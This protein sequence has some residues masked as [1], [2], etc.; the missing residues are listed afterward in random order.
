[1]EVLEVRV[2]EPTMEQGRL[3]VSAVVPTS[4]DRGI[5]L[6][7]SVDERLAPAVTSW[8]GPFV[9]VALW[10]AAQT[11]ATLV[12]TGAPVSPSLLRNL[13]RFQ[14]VWGTWKG[15]PVVPI[16]AEEQRERPGRPPAAVAACSGGVDSAFTV[17]RHA[18][19]RGADEPLVGTALMVQGLDI[20]VDDHDGFLGAADRARRMTESLGVELVTMATNARA[21]N[22]DWEMAHGLVLG[23]ALTLLSERFGVG[24]IPASSTKATPMI[25]PWGSNPFTDPL[26]GSGTFDV[27]HDGDVDKMDK[28]AELVAWPEAVRLVRVCWVGS[29]R[30][31]G[32]CRKC[33][34]TA[35]YFRAFGSGAECFEPPIGDDELLELLHVNR[36][37]GVAGRK[38]HPIA[39]L[40][41]DRRGIDAPWVQELRR[42]VRDD[43]PLRLREAFEAW[44][45]A[46]QAQWLLTARA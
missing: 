2:L 22:R 6:W 7:F 23:A 11:N 30:N 5:E 36:E 8:A 34:G 14:R 42:Q 26:M 28:F 39:L 46:R 35:I 24:L 4:A 45:A 25:L 18:P 3:R 32:R 1:M 17:W 21:V 16:Q 31:C 44:S 9:L 40:E 43:E 41:L 12:V 29:D 38:W 20:G 10:W 19:V 27:V 33:M 13:E 15:W 37:K